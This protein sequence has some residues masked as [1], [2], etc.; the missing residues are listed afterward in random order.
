MVEGTALETRQRGNPFESSN[1]SVSAK[2]KKMTTSNK[3]V[4][5]VC[6]GNWFRSQMAAAIYN[7]LTDSE[8]ADS[9]G[10]Y[11]GSNNEPEG[12]VIFEVMDISFFE[13]MESHGMNIR[14]NKS[15][16]LTEEMLRNFDLVISMAEDPYVPNFLR[17]DKKVIWWD[18]EN[19]IIINREVVEKTYIEIY[20][21]V[22]YL[23][24][25]ENVS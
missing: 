7:K 1:L 12:L 14:D 6:K 23:V 25:K 2:F 9:A 13:F 24:N 21:L 18:I 5:F 20:R 22:Y 8:N 4:L 3:K 11:V 10:T 19:P 15:K 17:L 16:K